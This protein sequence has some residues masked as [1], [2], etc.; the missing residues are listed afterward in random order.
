M[1]RFKL[2]ILL[3]LINTVGFSQQSITTN[4]YYLFD[5]FY[6][7]SLGGE[8]LYNPLYIN[9]IDQWV[10]FENSPKKITAGFEFSSLSSDGFSFLYT[11]NNQGGSF[12]E[13]QLNFN[14]SKQINFN[15]KN[16]LSLGLGVLASQKISDFSNITTVDPNDN[17]FASNIS[18]IILDGSFGMNF[19]SN[20]FKIGISSLYINNSELEL[21]QNQTTRSFRN[22]R[23]YYL[24][25]SH[26]FRIDE[27][28]TLSPNL[29]INL[30]SQDFFLSSFA[31]LAN[32]KKTFTFGLSNRNYS[33]YWEASKTHPSYRNITL[34]FIL[35]YEF[36]KFRAFYNYEISKNVSFPS[37][38]L[39]IGY[40]FE[41]LKRH[42][43]IENELNYSKTNNNNITNPYNTKI[44][45]QLHKEK[46]DLLEGNIDSSSSL[47]KDEKVLETSELDSLKIKNTIELAPRATFGE[48]SLGT[49][50]E[51]ENSIFK[52]EKLTADQANMVNLIM[53]DGDGNILSNG[54]KIENGFAFSHIPTNGKYFYKL[55]NMPDSMGIDLM[56]INIVEAGVSKKVIAS[57]IKDEEATLEA[58]ELDSLNI[59][60]PIDLIPNATFGE[61]SLGTEKETTENSIFKFEKLT[62][63]QANMVNLVMVDE[64]GNILSSGEKIENGFAFS[65]IPPNGKY[66]YK[67][68]NMPDS[69]GIDLMEINIVEAGVSKKVV[70]ILIKEEKTLEVRAMPNEVAKVE[71]SSTFQI[72]I[73]NSTIDDNNFFDKYFNKVNVNIDDINKYRSDKN[74]EFSFDNYSIT[75]SYKYFLDS[76]KE[77][78][79]LHKNVSVIIE[80]HT[81]N[82]GT[83]QYNMALS[84]RRA[85]SVLNYLIEKG[86]DK[87]ILT[88]VGVGEVRPIASNSSPMGRALN[89]RTEIYIIYLKKKE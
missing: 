19:T 81:D 18:E 41:K 83:E 61:L 25:S 26:V 87:K 2:Y 85:N 58:S 46:T 45:N 62:A 78:I 57:F 52:F 8:D 23:Q 42:K 30:L 53:V 49:E 48:L 24:T 15:K 20:N 35:G 12:K 6:N 80:G 4:Q 37:H 69:M 60:N 55:E 66:F 7:P 9:Y 82:I 79:E 73:H 77:F 27:N 74:V 33:A 54:E 39:T 86:I 71:D 63:D 36:K 34:G 47:V 11:Q 44:R 22:G 50:K 72:K 5:Y 13:D 68:E 17:I 56:E 40:H 88:A 32:F 64:A 76:L 21:S 10:G 31:L 29:L 38:E 65:R 43:V 14:Y 75:P 28:L 70:A 84:Q 67:L 59:K 51:T 16:K 1:F 3:F 89:R